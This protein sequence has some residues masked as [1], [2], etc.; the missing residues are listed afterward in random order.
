MMRPEDIQ[1][2]NNKVRRNWKALQS[3]NF[4]HDQHLMAAYNNMQISDKFSLLVNA[5]GIKGV[6][7]PV[8]VKT[9]MTEF[10][11]QLALP[12][13]IRTS[14]LR[15]T[16]FISI[17][18]KH[19]AWPSAED[20]VFVEG[21]MD[22]QEKKEIYLTE[23]KSQAIADNMFLLSFTRAR[24]QGQQ[25][26]PFTDHPATEKR[27]VNSFDTRYRDNIHNDVQGE[28][29]SRDIVE[30]CA[31][32]ENLTSVGKK[33]YNVEVESKP[34]SRKARR[35]L[36]SQKI[37]HETTNKEGS[38]DINSQEGSDE[39]SQKGL[40]EISQKGLDV[41]EESV[42]INDSNI[43]DIQMQG[44]YKTSQPHND[45]EVQK[46]SEFRDFSQ[47]HQASEIIDH[48]QE[49]ND[50]QMLKNCRQSDRKTGN[51]YSVR[52]D[53]SLKASNDFSGKQHY[54]LHNKPVG[55]FHGR[56]YSESEI[57]KRQWENANVAP[58]RDF[59]KHNAN[60]GRKMNQFHEGR[61]FM[62]GK[63]YNANFRMKQDKFEDRSELSKEIQSNKQGGLSFYQK[64][65]S[66][67]DED[68]ELLYRIP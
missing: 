57:E 60:F 54:T 17:L 53:N 38:D 39:I 8:N 9:E 14:Q 66:V 27:H 59:N 47:P 31:N 11:K 29:S 45:S 49:E 50:D 61:N 35:R 16:P 25:I 18:K 48:W 19:R 55:E 1:K 3:G 56:S 44:T 52:G 30:A 68:G 26:H 6:P 40:D 34:L 4:E 42:S 24:T 5:A 13:G 15:V 51:Q 2:H 36:L 41:Q 33:V 58:D 37:N 62:D 28:V 23:Q 20:E 67:Y 46:S 10:E 21:K 63:Q 64:G 43:K 65:K 32:Q 22:E 12:G 7:M